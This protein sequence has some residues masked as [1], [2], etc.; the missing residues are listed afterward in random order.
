MT[1]KRFTKC[2]GYKNTQ[3]EI[4]RAILRTT[5]LG[6]IFSFHVSSIIVR[7]AR[8]RAR[9][10]RRPVDRPVPVLSVLLVDDRRRRVPYVSA[11][12]GARRVTTGSSCG[13]ITKQKARVKKITRQIPSDLPHT[14]P[15]YA[16]LHTKVIP[17][18]RRSS[19]GWLIGFR[20]DS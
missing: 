8:A 17:G 2:K 7:G 15:A 10:R 1:L 16:R 20:D 3:C 4:K 14:V 19:T 12:S 6:L 18:S 5:N 11:T 9:E 13:S